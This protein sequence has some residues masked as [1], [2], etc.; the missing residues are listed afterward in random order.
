MRRMFL[1]FALCFALIVTGCSVYMAARQPQSKPANVMTPGTPRI[2]V[3]GE[4]GTPLESIVKQSGRSDIFSLNYEYGKKHGER[5][6]ASRAQLFA[7]GL[8]QFADTAARADL[9]DANFFYEIDYDTQD[10][11]TKVT[12]HAEGPTGESQSSSYYPPA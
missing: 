6:K 4:L 8:W 9:G 12:R 2:V 3:L 1:V 5:A 10:R 7:V 11:V